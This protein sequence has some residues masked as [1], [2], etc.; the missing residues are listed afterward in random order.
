MRCWIGF[1]KREAVAAKVCRLSIERYF[2]NAHVKM[3]DWNRPE[4]VSVYNRPYTTDHGQFIDTTTG[5]PF[6]TEF[7]F[8]RFLVPHLENYRGWAMYCD[9]D[10]L[11]RADV[12]DLFD[13]ADDRFACLVV[14][15]DHVPVEAKK[16]DGVKQ[17][18]YFRKNWSSLVLWNCGHSANKDLTPER[19]NTMPGAWLH[20]FQ[21]LGEFDIG[22]LPEEYNWLI[23]KNGPI[24][25]TTHYRQSAKIKAVHFTEGGPWFPGYENVPYAKEWRAAERLV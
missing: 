11:F 7:S 21:W 8:T 18:R 4:I 13:L 5:L 10:F 12:R 3:L 20:G 25:P 15:H 1:D 16:M 22:V 2:P 6:S 14:P 23:G 17:T 9:C 19:V 24:S